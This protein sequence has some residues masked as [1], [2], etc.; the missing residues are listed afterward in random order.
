MS[1]DNLRPNKSFDVSIEFFSKKLSLAEICAIVGKPASEHSYSIG[2]YMS[3]TRKKTASN[4]RIFSDE[5]DEA[6]LLKHFE[7]A[8]EVAGAISHFEDDRINRMISI[9]VYSETAWATIVVPKAIIEWANENGFEI[10]V[11]CY[12]NKPS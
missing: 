5:P 7:R 1:L 11:C 12:A 6:F 9:A 4:L 10:E 2:D 3:P 8:K